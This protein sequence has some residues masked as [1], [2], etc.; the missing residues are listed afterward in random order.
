MARRPASAAPTPRPARRGSVW[1]EALAIILVLSGLV[2]TLAL[3]VHSLG[4][5]PPAK[6][7]PP[8]P[9]TVLAAIPAPAEPVP[10]PIPEGFIASPLVVDRTDSVVSSLAREAEATRQKLGQVETA[11]SVLASALEVAR[12]QLDQ[13]KAGRDD[14]GRH[15]ELLFGEAARL[16]AESELL[17][18][19]IDLLERQ[20][21]EKEQALQAARSQPGYAILPYKGPNGTWRRPI[22]V[23]CTAG[24]AT[25]PPNG[26]TFA[27]EE[28]TPLQGPGTPF[29]TSIIRLCTYIQT[30][31]APDG[32][33]VIPYVVF[34]VRP[35]GIRPFYEA[36]SRVEALGIS[37]GYELVEQETPVEFPA[38][39]DPTIWGDIAALR[40]QALAGRANRP[41]LPGS[42][43]DPSLDSSLPLPP[44]VPGA[45]E[46][47][48]P[49]SLDELLEAEPSLADAVAGRGTGVGSRLG[50]PAGL[51]ERIL[52]ARRVSEAPLPRAEPALAAAD[53][54]ARPGTPGLPGP[55]SLG[56]PARPG[57]GSPG[58]V[59]PAA[60]AGPPPTN[61]GQAG[62]TGLASSASEG[63]EVPGLP[64]P[65]AG[66]APQAD[67]PPPPPG[68]EAPDL[69]GLPR[70]LQNLASAARSVPS[71]RPPGS[72]GGT[73]AEPPSPL[74]LGGRPPEDLLKLQ[75]VCTSKGVI[76][77]PGGYKLPAAALKK[78]PNRLVTL[79]NS[80]VESR[81][82]ASPDRQLYPQVE[83]LI[84]KAGEPVYWPARQ[85]VELQWPDWLVTWKVAEPR[86]FTLFGQDR[87]R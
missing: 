43:L 54:L 41:G 18:R 78:D 84:E 19:E 13:T 73:G 2:G 50:P 72:P 47:H 26:P 34:V 21:K 57:L 74:D 8:A 79:L 39:D 46:I 58:A 77:H 48:S 33:T 32:A 85:S 40:E 44:P 82:R 6:I 51:E 29:I 24:G 10:P 66:L 30:A 49:R 3:L 28:L 62:Q 52:A 4:R 38:L 15:G 7:R 36:R 35:D 63:I 53:Q 86:P 56:S 45:G 81:R 25:L 17:G 76:V 83:F 42:P 65:P 70:A 61:P 37:Y 69:S 11:S 55:E 1:A 64:V 31:G 59:G 68:F 12:T 87:W 5:T 16:E 14:L 75:V 23:E 60:T 80:L 9:P 27:L 67:L 71:N 20:A 22:A